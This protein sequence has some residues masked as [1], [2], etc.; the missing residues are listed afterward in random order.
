MKNN[1]T[2]NNADLL[3]MFLNSLYKQAFD[4]LLNSEETEEELPKEKYQKP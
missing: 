1:S 3:Y 4:L 2:L